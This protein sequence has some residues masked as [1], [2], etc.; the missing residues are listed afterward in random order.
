MADN[1]ETPQTQEDIAV[2]GTEEDWKEHFE[3]P[4]GMLT[5]TD[6]QFLWGLKSY[7]DSPAGL[8]H[9]RTDI[10]NRVVNGVLDL[11]YLSM[12]ELEQREQIFET[13]EQ[14]TVGGSLRDTV[15]SFIEFLY[16]GLE[17]DTE[18]LEESI[19]MGVYNGLAEVEGVD[20]YGGREVTVDIDVKSGYNIDRLLQQ[21]RDGQGH[22]LSPTEIGV[23][24]REGLLSADDIEELEDKGLD[25]DSE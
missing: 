16:F 11:S 7:E 12:M 17:G 14:E 4:R 18:W 1:D 6:R 21:L 22:T 20:S 19:A 8:S 15:A 5:D 23:L 25:I 2:F 10:R 9:R 3:R 24:V 13:L